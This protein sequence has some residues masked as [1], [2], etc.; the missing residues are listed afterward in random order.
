M[1][2]FSITAHARSEAP[3]VALSGLFALFAA[4][5]RGSFR[6]FATSGRGGADVVCVPP[7]A[8]LFWFVAVSGTLFRPHFAAAAG[9]DAASCISAAERRYRAVHCHAD[10]TL[11]GRAGQ[12]KQLGLARIASC[13]STRGLG[14]RRPPLGSRARWAPTLSRSYASPGSGIVGRRRLGGFLDGLRRARG[15]N[16][17]RWRG[18]GWW[19]SR[20]GGRRGGCLGRRR[21][22]RRRR[23]CRSCARGRG[24]ARRTRLAG[25]QP[26]YGEEEKKPP[27][28]C[29]KPKWGFRFFGNWLVVRVGD[30]SMSV[31]VDRVIVGR[32]VAHVSAPWRATA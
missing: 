15:R 22:G 5:G 14:V 6:F 29:G 19:R 16:R 23:C 28:Q 25:K 18:D 27:A 1:I 20:D 12:K 30:H 31:V 4:S 2:T 8:G 10:A 3:R 21:R 24:D 13:D 9:V 11:R 32:R 17:R 7:A 26:A